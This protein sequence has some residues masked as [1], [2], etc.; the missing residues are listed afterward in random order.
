MNIPFISAEALKDY[1]V[2]TK[3]FILSV[4]L[5]AALLIV[6]AVGVYS[7]Y[8]AKQ[9]LDDMYH[10]NLMST[11]YL[12]DAN[13]R[14][15]SR[16]PGI[17]PRLCLRNPAGIGRKGSGHHEHVGDIAVGLFGL[18]EEVITDASADL[19]QMRGTCGAL[20]GGK[21]GELCRGEGVT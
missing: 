17:Y 11:Q 8:Q 18:G 14:L 16:N 19:F 21:L 7:N 3:V 1:A 12:N 6:A 9:A 5:M 2:R 4:F 15:R 13:N 20:F 10:H